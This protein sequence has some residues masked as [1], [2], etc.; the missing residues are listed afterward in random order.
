MLVLSQL[1]FC[2]HADQ[3]QFS[4]KTSTAEVQHVVFSYLLSAESTVARVW[5]D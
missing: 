2:N 3:P 5:L 4:H 1:T